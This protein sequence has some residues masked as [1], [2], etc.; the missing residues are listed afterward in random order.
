[1]I[2]PDL[3]SLL[4]LVRMQVKYVLRVL[5]FGFAF[6]SSLAAGPAYALFSQCP[7]IGYADGCSILVEITPT[8]KLK[9]NIDP[10]ILP[11]DNVEDT[12]VGVINNSGATVFGI[13]LT[14]EDIF[15]FDGDG[16]GDPT[17]SFWGSGSPHGPYLGGPFGSTGY[18]GPNTSFSVIDA[19]TGTVNFEGG[20]NNGANLWFSLEGAP[21]DI[22]LTSSVTIDPGHGTT[23]ANVGQPV[24]TIGETD[25]P[26]NNPPAGKLHEDVLTVAIANNLKITLENAKYT[27]TMTK[28]DSMSC[29]TYFERGDKANKA[30]SNMFVSVHVNAPTS[31]PSPCGTGTSVLYNSTKTSSKTLA[32][33][34]VS[35]IASKLG[36]GILLTTSFCLGTDNVNVNHDGTYERNN[37]AVL[38]TTASRMTAV[39]AETARLSPPDEDIMHNP[40]SIG[41]AADGIFSGIDA[42]VN[43]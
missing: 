10:S 12:L 25:Y 34:M 22:K 40:A 31:F 27:V 1:M 18:E 17:G 16:A 7:A 30:R 33:L 19:D 20:L 14:G 6:F 24:G 39:I 35:Q 21:L 28:T 13:S 37:L 8:G 15:G 3:T 26:S 42:F 29:P 38:K 32:H 11:Y 23:C 41:K 5:G 4:N 2:H 43:Q 9:F 36:V